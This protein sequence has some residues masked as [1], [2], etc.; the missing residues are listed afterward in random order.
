MK[1]EKSIKKFINKSVKNGHF[2]EV[3]FGNLFHTIT[4]NELI[5]FWISYSAIYSYSKANRVAPDWKT[6]EQLLELDHQLMSLSYYPKDYPKKDKDGNFYGDKKHLVEHIKMRISNHIHEE[7]KAKS[8]FKNQPFIY[9]IPYYATLIM[10]ASILIIFLLWIIFP[11]L[12]YKGTLYFKT[13]CFSWFALVVFSILV[14]QIIS[15]LKK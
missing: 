6:K 10:F 2:D 15:K 4:Y 3:E 13:V 7:I 14:R 11:N 5:R 9:K 1:T 12:K 8:Y